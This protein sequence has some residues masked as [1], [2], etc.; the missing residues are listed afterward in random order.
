M[1]NNKH[2][3]TKKNDHWI[4]S[5]LLINT[6]KETKKLKVKK[7]LVFSHNLTTVFVYLILSKFFGLF[8]FYC[9]R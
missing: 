8:S 7:Y 3:M 1:K 2:I 6:E 9:W 4:S 5:F